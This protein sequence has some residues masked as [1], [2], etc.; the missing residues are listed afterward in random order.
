MYIPG[1]ILIKDTLTEVSVSKTDIT[2]QEEL[3]GAKIELYDA[4]N[5]LVEWWI[6]G[7]EAH[8]IKGLKTGI[9]YTLKETG[10]PLGYTIAADTKF[11]IDETGKVH[12]GDTVVEGGHILI[13]DTLT[14]VS[15][16]KTDITGQAFV[17]CAL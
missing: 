4:D 11:T 3:E 13:K 8:E 2:G 9:E 14:E 16:S 7:T 6:S 10:A 17:F 15:V 12:S 5:N 1:H